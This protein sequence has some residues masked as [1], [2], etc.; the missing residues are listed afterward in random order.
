MPRGHLCKNRQS[1]EPQGG[2][3][4]S[5]VTLGKARQSMSR[6][7]VPLWSSRRTTPSSRTGKRESRPNA[8]MAIALQKRHG[9]VA[10]HWLGV[11]GA[12]IAEARGTSIRGDPRGSPRRCRGALPITRRST[13]I[14]A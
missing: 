10:D 3:T 1:K 14:R 4:D 11:V 9:G 12:V 13:S 2:I 6:G 7:I 5:I 8:V